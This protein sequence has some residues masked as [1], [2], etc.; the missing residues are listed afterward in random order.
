MNP[1]IKI[2]AKTAARFVWK[3][4]AVWA[5]LV[6]NRL[7][8]YRNRRKKKR[9]LEIGPGNQRIDDFETISIVAA[10]VVDYVLDCSRRLPFPDNTFEVI[11]ASHV[12]EHVPWYQVERTLREWTRILAPGGALELWV[13]DAEKICAAFLDAELHGD[14]YIHRD[15]WYRYN[16]ERDPCLWASGRIFS[17]GDGTGAPASENWHRAVF[18]RRYLKATLERLGLEDVKE[19]SRA[20]VRG[21]DHGWINLGFRAVKP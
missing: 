11:Y 15:G 2:A 19:M 9:K 1:H 6:Q 7:N 12:L 3:V 8:L 18:S 13:P 17:Y 16:E 5:V 20:E 4:W 14:V 10:R 21:F